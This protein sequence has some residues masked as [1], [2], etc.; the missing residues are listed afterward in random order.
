MSDNIDPVERSANMRGIKSKNTWP[1]LTVRRLVYGMGYRYRL[2][3]ARLPGKPDL[4]LSRLGK[5][6]EVRGCFWH[7]HGKCIDS[8]VPKSRT[9]YW[10]P[11]L[12]RNQERDAD[13]LRILRKQ[14]WKVLVIW[15]CEL[16]KPTAVARRIRRFLNS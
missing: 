9:E 15:E 5:I 2:H 14:G 4:V 7:H 3:V 11:K 6:I 16:A 13:N 8:H 12:R 10:L 1:E